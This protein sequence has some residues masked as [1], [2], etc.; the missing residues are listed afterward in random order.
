MAQK[1]KKTYFV[2]VSYISILHPSKGVVAFL[3]E[4]DWVSAGFATITNNKYK[5]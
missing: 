3:V 1:I 2:N 4:F 5:V